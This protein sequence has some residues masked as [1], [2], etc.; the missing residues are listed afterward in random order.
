MKPSSKAALP[1][2]IAAPVAAAVS[3][4]AGYV[5]TRRTI[6]CTTSAAT[7]QP[8][9]IQSAVRAVRSPRR[10]ITASRPGGASA[11]AEQGLDLRFEHRIGLGADDPLRLDR[12]GRG[13]THEERGRAVHAQAGRPAAMS[14]SMSPL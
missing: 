13:P 14:R 7:I 1:S 3:S 12:V 11:L 8:P 6:Q 5:G 4:R 10:E 2:P 9:V